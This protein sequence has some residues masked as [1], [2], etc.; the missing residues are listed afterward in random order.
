MGHKIMAFIVGAAG[1][2]DFTGSIMHQHA[3][4]TIKALDESISRL[5]AQINDNS[6]MIGDRAKLEADM[7]KIGED[8]SKAL[9]KI[10]A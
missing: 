4:L 6:I 2:L 3:E 9:V 10:D 5:R 7:K 1:A 8:F